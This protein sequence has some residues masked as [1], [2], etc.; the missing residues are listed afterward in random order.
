MLDTVIYRTWNNLKC[1]FNIWHTITIQ[2][3]T[4]SK[5]CTSFFSPCFKHLCW[6]HVVGVMK[7]CAV[8]LHV[9]PDSCRLDKTASVKW[10]TFWVVVSYWRLWSW[11]SQV[12]CHTVWVYKSVKPKSR[13]VEFTRERDCRGLWVS[14][15]KC[16]VLGSNRDVWHETTVPEESLSRTQM[17]PALLDPFLPV[18]SYLPVSLSSVEGRCVLLGVTHFTHWSYNT[19]KNSYSINLLS[20]ISASW[21]VFC[22]VSSNTVNWSWRF[23]TVYR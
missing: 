20:W 16:D 23:T 17:V 12:L 10:A 22:P 15:R 18:A 7:W 3:C 5:Y 6:C 8:T 13:T 14:F 19:G 9:W 1:T 2:P 11:F 21:Q 4:F